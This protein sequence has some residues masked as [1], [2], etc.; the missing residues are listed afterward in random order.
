M[1]GHDARRAEK[2]SKTPFLERAKRGEGGGEIGRDVFLKKKTRGC[3][4]GS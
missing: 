2:R 4:T 1:I 3:F